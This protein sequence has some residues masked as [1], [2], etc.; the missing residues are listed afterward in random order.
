MVYTKLFWNATIIIKLIWNLEFVIIKVII[1]NFGF[2][3]WNLKFEVW[4]LELNFGII[5]FI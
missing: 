5:L 3:I 1:S 2:E 4:D